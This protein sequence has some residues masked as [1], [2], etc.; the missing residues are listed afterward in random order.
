MSRKHEDASRNIQTWTLG[1]VYTVPGLQNYNS[2]FA[3][4]V[5]HGELTFSPHGAARKFGYTDILQT[6]LNAFSMHAK[7]CASL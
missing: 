3:T 4:L 1:G 7:R 6:N 5:L 2:L